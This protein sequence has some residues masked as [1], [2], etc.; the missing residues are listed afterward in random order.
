M[1]GG[2]DLARLEL[3]ALPDAAAG[4]RAF[5]RSVL[6]SLGADWALD[7]ATLVCSELVTNALLHARTDFTV[8]IQVNDHGVRIQ[9]VDGNLRAPSRPEIPPIATSGRGLLLVEALSAKWGVELR[10]DGKA[11]WAD[12]DRQAMMGPEH[13]P[14][15]PGAAAA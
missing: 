11:V 9:V 14:Q 2:T 15:R 7:D 5:V 13:Q 4:A 12:L 3:T 1:D 6:W 10:E 8:E